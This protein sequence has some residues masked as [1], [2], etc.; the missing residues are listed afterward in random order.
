MFF[1]DFDEGKKDAKTP[2]E[3]KLTR[4]IEQ[5][6][7]SISPEVIELFYDF[8]N[9]NKEAITDSFENRYEY[10]V[11]KMIKTMYNNRKKSFD[12]AKYN[13]IQVAKVLAT[14]QLLFIEILLKIAESVYEN[15]SNS[16]RVYYIFDNL[17]MI[18]GPDNQ[19]FLSM[20]GD[21]WNFI[22]EMQSLMHT[23]SIKKEYL[24]EN[25]K[26]IDS[27]SR[28][29]YIFAMRETTSMHIGDHLRTRVSDFSRHVDVSF[30]VNKSFIIKKRYDMLIKY[31]DS[32]QIQNNAFI[33]TAKCIE[34]ITE[35]KF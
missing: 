12:E 1:F 29:K 34:Q 16:E 3:L 28:F 23:L 27:Y 26:W 10:Y 19:T 20:I 7:K 14:D 9:R 30:G 8:Y 25:E 2:L 4:Q 17:D 22:S 31:V 13:F 32:G 18:S 33:K 21:F 6:L 5:H 15:K 11:D 24:E 35:D